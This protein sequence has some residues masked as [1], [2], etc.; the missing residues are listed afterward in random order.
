MQNHY[1][2]ATAPADSVVQVRAAEDTYANAGAP[3]G[4]YGSSSSLAVRGTSLYTSYLRFNLPTA[5][6]GTVLKAASLSVKT[7]TMSG[8]GTADTVSV[9]PVT[10][11]WTEAGTTYNNR[12]ATGTPALGSFA[13]VPDGS[14]VHTTGLST[15]AL[16]GALGTSYGL[17]LAGPGTDALWL[18][19]SEAAANEGT[20]QLTLTFGAP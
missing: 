5:P 2:L 3:D 13:G 1:A 7:S 9:V 20:P 4:N 17:A 6:A 15:A 12:P 19:S 11:T 10:G 14:A 8:A 18:W 16:A